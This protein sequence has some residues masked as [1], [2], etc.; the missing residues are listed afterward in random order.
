[1]YPSVQLRDLLPIVIDY[2]ETVN[3]IA[4][5]SNCNFDEALQILNMILSIL[6][7][8]KC[9]LILIGTASVD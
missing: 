6:H 1:M 9:I 2:Q 7:L 4:N 5:I 8:L 3:L